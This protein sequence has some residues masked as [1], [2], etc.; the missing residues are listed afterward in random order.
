MTITFSKLL[1]DILLALSDNLAAVWSR[2]DVITPWAEEAMLS[3]PIL[4]PMHYTFT[5]TAPAAQNPKYVLDM[6]ADFREIVA[7]EY[8][9]DQQ[10]PS[11]L[12]RKNHLDPGFYTD[13]GYYDVDHDFESGEGWVIY[14]SGG[15]PE[16][17]A[18]EMDYFANHV[19]GLADDS[20]DVI[21]VPD[22]YENILIAYCV[23][24]GFRE[25]LAK[26]MQDPTTHTSVI[27]QMTEMTRRA[28]D[29]YHLLVKTARE[30]L[31]N[32][33]VSPRIAADK[34]DRVY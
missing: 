34:F 20:V 27:L 3:F 29:N 33:R 18:I 30:Q 21:S 7:V 22:E 14:F 9:I 32:S 10:P 2:S 24:K 11:Y 17:E 26:A 12:E 23:A 13:D 28:E 31:A 15:V 25:R 19:V 5:N 8:P 1:T 16:G 6:P 4:R